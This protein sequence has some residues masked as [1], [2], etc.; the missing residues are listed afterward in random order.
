[1]AILRAIYNTNRLDN[2]EAKN[3]SWGSG[4]PSITLKY[5]LRP[6]ANL[7]PNAVCTFH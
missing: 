5:H 1:M 3:I 2:G 7:A 4:P 6:L